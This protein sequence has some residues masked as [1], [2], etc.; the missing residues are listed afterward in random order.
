MTDADVLLEACPPEH[1]SDAATS[2]LRRSVTVGQE[3]TPEQDLDYAIR[4]IV[5]IAQRALSPGVNDPTTALY[6]I[7]RIKEAL[8]ALAGREMPAP[9]RYDDEGR[10]RIVTETAALDAVACRAFAAVAR[11]ADKDPEVLAYLADAIDEIISNSGEHAVEGLSRLRED[12][13]RSTVA[14]GP[15]K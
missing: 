7:D 12:I 4:R 11:Y 9:V 2:E 15:S 1:A 5:E 3:R 13:A 6:C 14:F 10:H 8:L